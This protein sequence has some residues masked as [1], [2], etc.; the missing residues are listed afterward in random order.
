MNSEKGGAELEVHPEGCAQAI[1]R[2]NEGHPRAEQ[3][4][5]RNGHSRAHR[6]A[7]RR[8]CYTSPLAEPTRRMEL[9]PVS[10]HVAFTLTRQLGT[11]EVTVSVPVQ[12]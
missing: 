4:P 10:L 1:S 7:E 11:S 6:P 2:C 3:L 8:D 5:L 12:E 9:F